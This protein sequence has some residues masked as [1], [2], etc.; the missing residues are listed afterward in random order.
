MKVKTL[1]QLLIET[2]YDKRKTDYLIQGITKGFDIGY[3]GKEDVKYR[4]QNL[5]LNG[6][7]KKLILWNKVMKEIKAERFTG[8]FD[9]ILFTNYIQSPIGLV[10]KDGGK[11]HRLIFHLSYPWGKGKSLNENTPASLCSVQYLDFNR[12]IELCR[13]AGI[14]CKCSKSDMK[15]AFRNLGILKAQ[16][17]YLIMTAQS[18]LNN[19]YYFYL[20]KCLPFGAS[21][22]CAI[23]QDFSN[24]IA[25]ILRVKPGKENVNY[26]DNFLF[27]A[28][29]KAMCDVQ[30][31]LF[32]S[33]C[34]QINF[35]VSLEKT[36]F[37][38]TQIVFLGMLIDT[39]HQL[40][41]IPSDKI[42]KVRELF[43]KALGKDSRKITLKQLQQI[44]SFLNFLGKSI[45]PGRAFT[46]RLYA[47]TGTKQGKLKPHHHIRLTADMRSDLAMWLEFINHPS[48]YAREF[49]DFPNSGMP[50]K[51]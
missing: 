3:R 9:Q 23:F 41:L 6:P 39:V 35:P 12:A 36:V 51:Y 45:L 13:L 34:G 25:H 49:M 11:D 27:V 42:A 21:I 43:T 2:K 50:V 22:S 47:A 24:A 19:K 30:I 44:C 32:L 37:S 10:P 14:G 7:E 26:L 40:V 31:D 29:L 48:V 18:P 4:A 33:I 16:W 1:H 28:L 8:P 5:K 38:T 15:S 17:K 46:R 20:N